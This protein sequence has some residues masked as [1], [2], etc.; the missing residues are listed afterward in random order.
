MSCAFVHLSKKLLQ[1]RFDEV[2]AIDRAELDG[3]AEVWESEHFFYELPGKWECSW[4]ATAGEQTAGFSINSIKP[5]GALHVHRIVVSRAFQG[6][7]IGRGLL[8]ETAN[9]ALARN[10]ERV[11]LRVAARN[12]A[13]VDFYRRVG[14][15]E[16]GAAGMEYLDLAIESKSLAE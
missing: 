11:T 14:F 5:G 3:L 12:A 9:S 1:A 6:Q 8:R 16:V 13:S 7:G 15:T 2:A 10:L 4:L